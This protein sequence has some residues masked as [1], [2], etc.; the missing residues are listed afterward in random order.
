[1]NSGGSP[2]TNSWAARLGR[3]I[4]SRWEPSISHCLSINLFFAAT[5]VW[6]AVYGLGLA[7][8]L[9]PVHGGFDKELAAIAHGMH[10]TLER[11]HDPAAMR[12]AMTVV[13]E[14]K[15]EMELHTDNPTDV[16]GLNIWRS[17]GIWLAGSSNVPRVQLAASTTLGFFNAAAN[18]ED[19]R[20]YAIC[21]QDCAY[22][23]EALHAESGRWNEF[24]RIMLSPA[25]LLFPLLAGFP[26]FLMLAIV[27]VRGALKPLRDLSDELAARP[28][29]DLAP[30]KVSWEF[31]SELKPIINAINTTFGR[32][33]TVRQRERNFLADAAHEIR[34]PLAVINAYVDALLHTEDPAERSAT[35]ERVQ[36]SMA[37]TSRLVNQLLS[38]ARMDA[39]ADLQRVT[40]DL[41]SVARDCL[42]A[43]ATEARH[44]AIELAY[45]G[46]DH[47]PMSSP[48]HAIESI[49]SNLVG[50][51][52]RYGCQNGQVE[53][54][55]T[56]MPAGKV[57]LSIC[58]DGPGIP[59][60]EQP[61]MFERF[62]RGGSPHEVTGAGLGLPIVAAAAR[63]L[64][65]VLEIQPGLHGRGLCFDLEWQ[66][67]LPG[68]CRT[69][70]VDSEH[71]PH[72]D[73]VLPDSPPHGCSM[74]QETD[75]EGVSAVDIQ[76]TI[77]KSDRLLA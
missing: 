73:R 59:A 4:K 15:H 55:V 28:P 30:V 52:V 45:E 70:V 61:A 58:D 50:N 10:K 35:A 44:K 42:A 63:Q 13:D 64:G 68:A 69:F 46:P 48:G 40:C 41:A 26:L 43:F 60:E 5:L 47:L 37:R 57:R 19:Y 65:A 39:E 31:A 38:L 11:T 14:V 16:S 1:M 34:T 77:P 12:A 17:D 25:S 21:I 23:I 62:R 36:A 6:A 24:N 27:T 74:G 33:E 9:W 56:T 7:I 3:A 22:R 20:G 54:H 51:A 66:T 76:P 32:L 53:I 2:V 71:R 29:G 8:M 67:E 72:P 49:I 18:G 75:K